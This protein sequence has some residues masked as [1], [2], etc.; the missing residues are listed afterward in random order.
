M[1][2][3]TN[4]KHNGILWLTLCFVFQYRRP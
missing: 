1:L 3:N 4:I 2:R